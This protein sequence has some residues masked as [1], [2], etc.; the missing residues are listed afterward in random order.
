MTQ[1]VFH[2]LNGTAGLRNFVVINKILNNNEVSHIWNEGI[3]E[4]YIWHE[5]GEN[6]RIDEIISG[7]QLS[8]INV[9]NT[10]I[11]DILYCNT[12]QKI[13]TVNT[14]VFQ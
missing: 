13:T 5:D 2:G 9:E 1:I 12:S 14:E 3:V 7:K 4:R 6:V 11:I 8:V 10:N